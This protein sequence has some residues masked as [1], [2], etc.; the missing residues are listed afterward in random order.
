MRKIIALTLSLLCAHIP[1]AQSIKTFDYLLREYAFGSKPDTS[2][3][4]KI[5]DPPSLLY[6]VMYSIVNDGSKT[7][8][9]RPIQ[10]IALGIMADTIAA[11]TI[12]VPF[13]TTLHK[14]MERDLGIPEFGWM[15][16]APGTDTTGI[17]WTRY[18]DL[19][20]YSI[21]FKCTRYQYQMGP[22]KQDLIVVSILRK[23][24]GV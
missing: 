21:S 5:I 10:T 14:E 20:S 4:Q 19:P 24:P 22:V 6:D 15:G 8:Y 11:I 13:D 12:Y 9:G 18:W 3:L 23:R 1:Y 16:F 7:L 17:I 2:K